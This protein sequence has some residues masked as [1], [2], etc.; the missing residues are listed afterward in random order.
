MPARRLPL[1][2]VLLTFLI[3]FAAL[4]ADPKTPVSAGELVFEEGQV[5]DSDADG[6]PDEWEIQYF[7]NLRDQSHSDDPDGDG[8]NNLA[9]MQA[10]TNPLDPADH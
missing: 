4:S 1:F 8:V 2:L 9:E 5:E 3:P 10:G 6:L 7:G